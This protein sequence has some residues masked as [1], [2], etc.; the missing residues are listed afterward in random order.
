M[1]GADGANARLLGIGAAMA[2]SPSQGVPCAFWHS[3]AS[4]FCGSGLVHSG[5]APA[6]S[7]VC[8]PGAAGSMYG[9]VQLTC[10]CLEGSRG[11]GHVLGHSKSVENVPNNV[12][13]S[14]S[15]GFFFYVGVQV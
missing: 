12:L 11:A 1:C 3:E 10:R 14:G 8:L 2:L 15:L 4:G 5:V 7:K 9:A 13:K 6:S